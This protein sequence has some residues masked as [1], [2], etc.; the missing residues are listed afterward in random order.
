MSGDSPISAATPISATPI[1]AT[2]VHE[3]P[4]LKAISAQTTQAV[5]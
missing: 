1:V 5:M 3:L 4:M 2:V